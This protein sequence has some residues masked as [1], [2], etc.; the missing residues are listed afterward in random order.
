MINLCN[1]QQKTVSLREGSGARGSGPWGTC[2]WMF[3]GS[4]A[5]GTVRS[6][7]AGVLTASR[8]PG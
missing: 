2:L 7:E 6:R 4:V 8:V 5:G 3:I 1:G